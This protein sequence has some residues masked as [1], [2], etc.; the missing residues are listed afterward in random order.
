MGNEPVAGLMNN[1]YFFFGGFLGVDILRLDWGFLFSFRQGEAREDWRDLGR[2]KM[3]CKLDTV[4]GCWIW[5][6][7]ERIFL[8]ILFA[9]EMIMTDMT[10]PDT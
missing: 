5:R 10:I 1:V 8:D 9:H 7:L 2:T 3:R 6:R 4:S